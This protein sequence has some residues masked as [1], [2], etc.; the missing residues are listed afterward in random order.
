VLMTNHL[1]LLMT[2]ATDRG[3][4]LLMKGLGQG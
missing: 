4:S 2:P 3:P 1:H